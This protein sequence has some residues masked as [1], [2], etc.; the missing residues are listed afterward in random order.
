MVRS[1]HTH[2]LVVGLS[3]LSNLTDSVILLGWLSG[4]PPVLFPFLA[5][6]STKGPHAK[7]CNLLLLKVLF[8]DLI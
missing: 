6:L 8:I 2:G 1:G 5:L 4:P 3:G 7:D